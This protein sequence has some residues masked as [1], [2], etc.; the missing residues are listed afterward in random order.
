[1]QLAHPWE[2]DGTFTDKLLLRMCLDV[3]LLHYIRLT[4]VLIAGDSF[5]LEL[6]STLLVQYHLEAEGEEEDHLDQETLDNPI[7]T[8]S[9]HRQASTI[10]LCKNLNLIAT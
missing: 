4:L 10:C 2:S 7:Q 1:M 6:D 8:T 3:N 5:R 9:S